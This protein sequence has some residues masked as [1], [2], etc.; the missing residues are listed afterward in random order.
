VTGTAAQVTAALHGLIFTA[1]GGDPGTG[2][3]IAVQDTLGLTANDSTTSVQCFGAGTAIAT[4]EGA[5]AVETLRAGDLV[6]TASGEALPVRWLGVQTIAARFADPAKAWPVRVAAGALG[7]GLPVRDLI[8]SPGHA[9]FLDGLLIQAGALAGRP[10]I[11]RIAPQAE[12][13]HYYHVELATHALL[14]AEG[15]A[16]ESYLPTPEDLP[17]DNR[18]ER[19]WADVEALHYPRVK[20]ARQVPARWRAAA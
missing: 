16:A 10:G 3:S 5:R 1:T 4:P 20:A 11:A 6:L 8:L 14:L 18:A 9:L 2:F 7:A 12:I 19:A 13:F 17:F 15:A